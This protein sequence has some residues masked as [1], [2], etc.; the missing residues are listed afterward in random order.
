MRSEGLIQNQLCLWET[1]SLPVAMDLPQVS[2][3][4]K[5]IQFTSKNQVSFLSL[6]TWSLRD[7]SSFLCLS[8]WQTVRASTENKLF[9]SKII[10]LLSENSHSYSHP[11]S[12][13]TIVIQSLTVA[14]VGFVSCNSLT[15][16][17]KTKPIM[18]KLTFYV[19]QR[20]ICRF[21]VYTYTHL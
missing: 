4:G 17:Y 10:C 15:L 3:I 8:A 2:Q 5:P 14:P 16:L 12:T 6:C 7:N 13:Q 20:G 11:F 1:H 21:E 9:E 19:L 18:H